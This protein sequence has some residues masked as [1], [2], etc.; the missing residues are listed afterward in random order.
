MSEQQQKL[1]IFFDER[2]AACKQRSRI[3]IE[4][5]RVDEGNIEKIRANVYD[6]FKTILSVAEKTGGKD[7]SAVKR[8]CLQKAEQIPMNWEAA[9]EKAKRNGDM[10]K[11]H[12]ESVKLDTIRKIKDMF[13]QTW[14]ETI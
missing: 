14:E 1:T 7:E 9:Y 13:L 6:I 10:E 5:D 8:F 4:D 12:L 3:L 2:I 11:M